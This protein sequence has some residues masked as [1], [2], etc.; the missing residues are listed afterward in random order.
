MGSNHFQQCMGISSFDTMTV[1]NDMSI[2]AESK[3]RNK[4]TENMILIICDV[5]PC[6][7]VQRNQCFEAISPYSV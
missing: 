6:S 4:S 5:T 1:N 2:E 3:S 7:L